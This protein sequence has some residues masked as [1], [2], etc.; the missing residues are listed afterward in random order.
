MTNSWHRCATSP[1]PSRQTSR[2]NVEV[3]P[4]QSMHV[5]RSQ[6]GNLRGENRRP[7]A[8]QRRP[9]TPCATN[10]MTTSSSGDG[11]DDLVGDR[12]ASTW[13]INRY[14]QVVTAA[15]QRGSQDHPAL[16]A[17]RN[18]WRVCQIKCVSAIVRIKPRITA[19]GLAAESTPNSQ[20]VLRHNPNELAKATGK[21]ANC[22]IPGAWSGLRYSFEPLTPAHCPN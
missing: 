12:R 15:D 1:D 13:S 10:V 21:V 3:E 11:D 20:L 6:H 4:V 5:Q 18:P 2:R 19:P 9:E 22:G 17:A 16:P 7:P 8:K 14:A